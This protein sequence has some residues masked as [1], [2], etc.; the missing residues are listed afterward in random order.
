M[1]RLC[2]YLLLTMTSP[3]DRTYGLF[4]F[5]ARSPA[6]KSLIEATFLMFI[7]PRLCYSLYV[8][9]SIHMVAQRSNKKLFDNPK[10][11]T[12]VFLGE[13]VVRKDQNEG[14]KSGWVRKLPI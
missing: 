10:L 5:T 2:G 6:T 1:Y 7:F 14:G 9:C 12:Q 8:H 3:N 4:D 13:G 11:S